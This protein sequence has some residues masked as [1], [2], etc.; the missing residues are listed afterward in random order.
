ML[1][2]GFSGDRGL[3][4]EDLACL[5]KGQ[6]GGSEGPTTLGPGSMFT[7][8]LCLLVGFREGATEDSGSGNDDLG[9]DAMSLL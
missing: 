7:G 1:D 8:S 9:D 3:D 2:G 6:A 5:V 4:V